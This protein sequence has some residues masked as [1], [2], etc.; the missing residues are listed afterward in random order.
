MDEFVRT[1][2]ICFAAPESEES[3]VP[4]SAK[5]A[6]LRSIPDLHKRIQ[7]LTVKLEEDVADTW[8]CCVELVFFIV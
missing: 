1:E 7:E 8:P 6:M 3:R 5:E 2:L 4:Q